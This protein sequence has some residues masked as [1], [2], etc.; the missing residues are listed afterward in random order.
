VD[1]FDAWLRYLFDRP[2]EDLGRKP[3]YWRGDDEPPS[4]WMSRYAEHDDPVATAERVRRLFSD[5]G[6][7][8]RP[9]SDEQVGHGL[10]VIVDSS[11]DGQIRA[12]TDRTVPLVLRTTGLRSIVTLFAQVFA[13]RLR[14]DGPPSRST[15]EYI[16][17]MFWDTAPI[18]DLG[19]DTVLDVLEDTLALDSVPCQKA[20]LHGLG[21][22]HMS[23]PEHVPVIVDRWLERHPH[24]PQD[25]RD[26]AT[27]A[28]A[29]MVN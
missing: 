29:G 9:Y 12:L 26:Y 3:W 28:R 10:K 16:C 22:A 19:D 17:F 25:L 24:A 14:G 6:N 27:Q 2:P 8:L 5:A 18:A 20:A 13:P 11:L 21:H 7:L 1:A 4:E 15:L 23:A